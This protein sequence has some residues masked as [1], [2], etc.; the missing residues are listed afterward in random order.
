MEARKYSVVDAS[1][2]PARSRKTPKTSLS[3]KLRDLPVGKAL[4]TGQPTYRKGK[5]NT[6]PMSLAWQ[7]NH[8]EFKGRREY[9]QRSVNGKIWMI[10]HK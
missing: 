5:S 7:I 10:R 6:T 9:R 8:K 1:Q 2:L 3:Q 4:N